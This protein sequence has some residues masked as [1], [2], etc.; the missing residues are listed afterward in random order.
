MP[1][2]EG[3]TYRARVRLTRIS[4]KRGHNSRLQRPLKWAH[5][6]GLVQISDMQNV[7]T[8]HPMCSTEA[9]LRS[10]AVRFESGTRRT[11]GSLPALSP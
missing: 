3:A 4:E 10:T 1:K 5:R 2:T 11:E 9:G 6:S 7:G 8:T